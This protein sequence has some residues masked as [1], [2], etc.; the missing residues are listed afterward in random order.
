MEEQKTME[1]MKTEKLRCDHCGIKKQCQKIV[2]NQVGN[3]IFICKECIDRSHAGKL[4]LVH[5]K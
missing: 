5:T 1:K 2:Y 4:P 3:V